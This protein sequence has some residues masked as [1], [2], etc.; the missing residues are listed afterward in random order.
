M[1]VGGKR[2]RASREPREAEERQIEITV[3]RRIF[4]GNL[5]YRTSWQVGLIL[6]TGRKVRLFCRFVRG[7]TAWLSA[8]R[9]G[10]S[11]S[12]ARLC[13]SCRT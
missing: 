2:E 4:V 3:A 11:T 5:S 9:G 10:P 1:T 13:H 12:S 8:G 7:S 6:G